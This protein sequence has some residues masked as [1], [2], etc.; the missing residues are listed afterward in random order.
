MASL[1]FLFTCLFL[2]QAA[3]APIVVSGA[4]GKT[5]SLTYNLLKKQ[6]AEVR[7]F[8]RN[9]TKAKELL[10][11]DKCDESEGIFAGDIREKNSMTKVM[12]GAGALV[13]LTSSAPSCD[14]SF[15][16]TYPVGA[17]PIDV[18]WVGARN[19]M[20]VFADT[21]GIKPVV[22]VS[23]MGTTTP[24]SAL[25]MMGKGHGVFYKLNFEAVLMTSGLPFTIL[26]PCRLGYAKGNN[27]TIEVGHD[28]ELIAKTPIQREDL[29]RVVAAAASI[30]DIVGNLRFDL[31]SKP[32]TPTTDAQ[33]PGLFKDA[34]FPWQAEKAIV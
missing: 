16:C 26:K 14:A 33:I 8:V 9:V 1:R 15:D 19:T 13:I 29:A 10:G 23:T 12:T 20:E 30:P 21:A 24:D 17:F 5:G 34:R 22:L 3:A 32:G 28:D 4:T 27:A 7:A 25:D 31:C 18:D 11:C 6:G 2:G